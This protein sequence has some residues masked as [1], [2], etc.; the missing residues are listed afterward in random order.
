M[1]VGR[2]AAVYEEGV[3]IAVVVVIDPGHARAHRFEIQ[4]FRRCG[5]LVV[6]MDPSPARYVMKL[7]VVGVRVLAAVLQLDPIIF[8]RLWLLS[9]L[10]LAYSRSQS[11]KR[12]IERAR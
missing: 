12:H 7:N 5:S 3:Q 8:L 2:V 1:K 11:R 9:R 4:L 6:E 10:G